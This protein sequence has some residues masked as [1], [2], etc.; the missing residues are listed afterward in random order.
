MKVVQLAKGVGHFDSIRFKEG[1][2]SLSFVIY[3]K[4][5]AINTSDQ[6]PKLGMGEA[7]IHYATN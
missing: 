5:N 2:I 3:R 6:Y 1:R 4:L 7:S